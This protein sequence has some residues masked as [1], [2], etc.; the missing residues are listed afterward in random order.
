[1]MDEKLTQLVGQ[2][3]SLQGH[4]EGSVTLEG[5]RPLANGYECRVRL[6]DGTLEET[7]ISQ[8]EVAALLDNLPETEIAKI[9]VDGDKLRLL[10]ESARIRLAYTH[11]RQFAVSLSAIRTLPHQIEAVYQKMLPQPRLRFLLADDP[12]A[13]KTIMAGLLIKELKLRQAVERILILCPAPLTIQWQ[14]EMLRWFGEPFDIIFSAVDQQ[15]LVNPW[16]KFSQVIA[17]I[18][19]AK[20]D[21]VRERVWQQHWDLVII[22]E[23]HKCSAR[24]TSGG[25]GREPK[26]DATKRYTLASQVTSQADLVLLLTATP[27]HGD[28]DKFAHFLR[29]IDP[30]LFPEPHRLKNQA[31][32]IRKSVFRLGQD[33]PWA[34]RRLKEDLKD[35]KGHR[36]FPDRH[37]RTVTFSLNS[38]EYALYKAVTAYINEFFSQAGPR[39]N[40]AALARTVFQR[41]LASSTCA[42]HESLKNR[43]KK[44]QGLLEELESLPPQQRARKIAWL[45]G[46]LPDAEQDEDD[47]DEATRDQL[48]DEFTAALELDQI[49][50]EI[51]A[52]GELVEQA[53]RVREQAND[54][55]LAALRDSL[56]EAQFSELRDGRGKLLIFT[57][58]RSTL[59]YIRE[60]L[61]TRGY[62]TCEIHGSMNPHERKRAQELFRTHAQI[63]VATEA[64]GEG[65]NLQ[66][67]HLM[68]NYDLPWNPTRLEQ[69][70]GRIHR[71]GQERDCYVFN[72]V[73]TESEDGH[74]V[75]EGRIL[76]RLLEKLE[77][78]KE[79]LAD[80]VYDV[81][82][83]VLSL[84][85]INLLEMLRQA[86]YDPRRLDEYIDQIDRIDPKKLKEYEEATG[87]ALAQ[88][89]VDFSEF[90]QQNL[91]VEEHRLMP[92]FVE[93]YF[94][95]A[96]REVGLKLDLRADGLWRIDH[97]PIDL[98]SERLQSVQHMGK[99][100]SS[101][102]KVTFHKQHLEQDAHLDAV[103][104]GPG[105]PLYAAVDERLNDRLASF[106]GGVSFYLDPLAS[107]PYRFH[108]FEI[109]IIGK[110]ARGKDATL[111]GELV[112]VREEAGTFEVVPGDLILNLLPHPQSPAEVRPVDWQS[113]ADF[114]KGG[115]QLECRT[116]CQEER[117][118]YAQIIRDYLENSFRVRLNRAQ[119]QAM[120]LLGEAGQKPEYKLAADEASRRV[121]ELER[122]RDDRMA[123]LERLTVARTGPVRHLA[124]A[125]IMSPS[126]QAEVQAL[127][128]MDE[129][130][131]HISRK[132]ELAAEDLVIAALTQEGF[133]P[134]RIQ[135]IGHLKRGFDLR[136]HRVVDTATGE[137]E[138]RR[139][140]VKGR[141]QG[142]AIRLTV[143]EWYKAQQLAETYWLYVVWDPLGDNPE[144][145]Y[146]QNPAARLDHAKR[147]IQ[148]ARLI[149]IPFQALKKTS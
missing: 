8:D 109:S 20:Q 42:I 149:E 43:L 14:D 118:R 93:A 130:E 53:R 44:Q 64:A 4:F 98:R 103:L 41:R 102:N 38:E 123:G 70:L 71:I 117:Q 99:A 57:E 79:A 69:R 17:S 137:I 97:V 45:Q 145:I 108:F 23:A 95:D 27:H 90:Q 105:H 51:A 36:L 25:A 94:R 132:I 3:I 127:G 12:G 100:D 15:Q 140:E 76:Q 40:S 120:R 92:C 135:R 96:A 136:A 122:D 63:C 1:M 49:R 32:E 80:R 91:E 125:L 30:D 74:P 5:V 146:I 142:Q 144:M 54:S 18:D 29:L 21:D 116:R 50:M 88:S 24:T 13:G 72:F 141:A 56:E 139:V 138:V 129:P 31:A 78:M 106:L 34:L 131:P 101:Y 48:A 104:L 112:T 11:D 66:F 26:V 46:R 148:A 73:A 61:Q 128:L 47:L 121:K 86:A 75:I 84:N 19:Y 9:S 83:E 52:L 110:D 65:I 39:R 67:C 6:Q 119:E 89:H 60:Y 81:L 82:G 143:N 111:Y 115:Y 28:E 33:C 126:S 147:E 107:S 87:I 133:P 113:A 7:I 37:A 85:D 77:Q 62:L 68:I 134:D 35:I 16:Q 124:T 22:D 59:S 114:L 58:H 2:L 10:I 55:K